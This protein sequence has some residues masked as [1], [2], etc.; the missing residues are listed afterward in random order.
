[1]AFA[2]IHEHDGR[3]PMIVAQGE[4]DVATGDE[5][6]AAIARAQTNGEEVWVDLSEV[7]FMDSTG[8]TALLVR[9]RAGALVVVC[10]PGPVRRVLEISGVERLLCVR[11]DRSAPAQP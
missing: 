3:R 7:E 8:V 2:V 11:D 4:V 10:P 1:M 5:F 9:R 6:A